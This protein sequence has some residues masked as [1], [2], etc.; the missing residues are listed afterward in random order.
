MQAS[1]RRKTLR[2]NE[3]LFERKAI[4]HVFDDGKLF[5]AS[6]IKVLWVLNKKEA[7]IALRAGFTAPGKIFKKAVD[8]NL[9]KRRMREAYRK[10]KHALENLLQEKKWECH[11]MFIY[12]GRAIAAYA[13]I[14]SKIVVTLQHLSKNI[15]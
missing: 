6:P 3:R 9:L 4:S 12:S 10:N 1:T 5:N 7:P 8:R 15:V 11:I 14:E 2:K 13:E